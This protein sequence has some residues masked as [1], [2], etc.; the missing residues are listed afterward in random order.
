MKFGRPYSWVALV[1]VAGALHG[2]LSVHAAP[3]SRDS[4]LGEFGA[5][6]NFLK[7]SYTAPAAGESNHY[8]ELWKS[9][10]GIRDITRVHGLTNNRAI[11]VTSHGE[12]KATPRGDRYVFVPHESRFADTN[13]RPAYS[14]RDLFTLIGP[15]AA[16]HIHNICVSG[17]NTEGA[18][19]ADEFRR[20]FP[21][22]TNITHVAAGE[23]GFEAMF[24]QAVT[25]PSGEVK[26]LFETSQRIEAGGTAYSLS[27]TA[28]PNARRLPPYIAE[29]FLPRARHPFKVQ[30]AGRELLA[31]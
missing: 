10:V 4:E 13:A 24:A 25:L 17:C 30:I 23:S 26:P 6:M 8:F 14:V 5:N 16:A 31:P 12:A 3:P 28:V 29:L 15:R 20:Y 19:R 18:L 21:N 27:N 22:A 1:C 7:A 9:G 2:A 11:F